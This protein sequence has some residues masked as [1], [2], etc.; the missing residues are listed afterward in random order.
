V[1]K[2][3]ITS[4]AIIVAVVFFLRIWLGPVYQYAYR[5]TLEVVTPDGP[6]TGSTVIV[7]RVHGGTPTV[8]SG[9]PQI[10]G[11]AIFLDIAPKPIVM[12]TPSTELPRVAFNISLTPEEAQSGN[13]IGEKTARLTPGTTAVIP[14]SILPEIVTFT[15]IQLPSSA[16]VVF[17]DRPYNKIDNFKS[18]FGDGYRFERAIIEIIY[19]F[20]LPAYIFG[21]F[22][23]S[24]WHFVAEPIYTNNILSRIPWVNDPESIREFD[25]ALARQTET[26]RLSIGL[27][28]SR[29]YQ[30]GF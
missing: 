8:I 3:I 27:G 13:T 1:R 23:P 18:I 26:G 24:K 9:G 16:E 28:R 14:A 10:W 30:Q 20:S 17:F 12:L 29:F 19:N 2:L 15:N 5:L 21:P 11:D 6:R 22:W 25:R 7:A 4:A